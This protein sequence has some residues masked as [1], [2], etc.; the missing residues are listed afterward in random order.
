MLRSL[1]NLRRVIAFAG[2]TALL[3][4][5][6]ALVAAAPAWAAATAALATG[7]SGASLP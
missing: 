3:A 4:S 6:G 5:G 1:R 2:S 7:G